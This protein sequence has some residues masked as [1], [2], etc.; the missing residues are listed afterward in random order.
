MIT[1]DMS[2]SQNPNTAYRT[3][4]EEIFLIDLDT[5]MLY[6]LNSVAAL[7]WDMSSEKT[8]ISEIIDRIT[9]EFEVER[10]VAEKDCLEFV[11]A[12][13]DRGLLTMD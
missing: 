7:V 12:F 13:M 6:S 1:N 9:E 8:T 5:S 3:I 4:A 11:S 2:L 10:S